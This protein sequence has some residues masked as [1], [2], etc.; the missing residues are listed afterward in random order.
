MN[1]HSNPGSIMMLDKVS[2]PTVLAGIADRSLDRN[3]A[4]NGKGSLMSGG[5]G[6]TVL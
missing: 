2:S 5:G 3:S 1:N 6:G 4:N